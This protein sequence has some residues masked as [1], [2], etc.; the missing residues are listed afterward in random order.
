M[1]HAPLRTDPV[2]SGEMLHLCDSTFAGLATRT[3]I[4]LSNIC[5]WP[6]HQRKGSLYEKRV[7]SLEESLES[8]NSL[9]S[10]ENGHVLLCFP[11]FRESPEISKISRISRKP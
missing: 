10:L 5:T 9:E 6:R 7:L 2:L 8:L 1:T 3:G 11:Q 4:V